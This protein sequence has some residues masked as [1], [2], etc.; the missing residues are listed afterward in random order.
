MF[1]FFGGDTINISFTKIIHCYEKRQPNFESLERTFAVH[2]II[3]CYVIFEENI[4]EK[5]S[6]KGIN[7]YF[8]RKKKLP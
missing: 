7:I 5:G 1:F 4:Y 6:E 2:I 8:C 3:F